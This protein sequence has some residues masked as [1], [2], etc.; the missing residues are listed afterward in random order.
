MH[1]KAILAAVAA[2]AMAIGF[3]LPR[4][5]G[6]EAQAQSQVALLEIGQ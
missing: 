2:V 6:D 3:A 5:G 4:P 1:V